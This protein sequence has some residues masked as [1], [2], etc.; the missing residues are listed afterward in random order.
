MTRS[1]S[2]T[3]NM[4]IEDSNRTTSK[5]LRLE[6]SLN[7]LNHI[8]I[9]FVTIYMSWMCINLDLKK[10]ALHAWLCTLGF[11]FLMAE[12]LMTHYNGN[13]MLFY[14][15]RKTKTTIHW[16]LQA[17][18]G[19]LGI[20]GALLK[21]IEK[22]VHFTTIHGKVGLAAMI[23]CGL[24]MLTGLSALY[25]Q[26]LKRLLQPLLNKSVHNFLGISGFVL[27]MV[28]Q[29]YGYETRFFMFQT[30][31]SFRT[32]MQVV[33]IFSIICC[34]LGPLKALWEKCKNIKESYQ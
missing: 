28:A 5:W 12:G 9:G 23:I 19:S 32:M 17:L 1:I 3:N 11:N 25:S 10:T 6:F 31:D 7:L 8:F 20:V 29:Y 24:S 2:Y 21:I 27:A 30:D 26:S 13:V 34:C 15:S 18:G 14:Y 33:T 16:V 4:P 22:P